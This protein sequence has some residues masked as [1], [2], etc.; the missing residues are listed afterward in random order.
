MNSS[1]SSSDPGSRWRRF[2]ATLL[3]VAVVVLGSIIAA[4]YMA[5]PYDTGRSTLMDKPGVRPQGPRT[6]AASRGRDPAFNA[7]IVGNSHI[8]LL[9][10]ERLKAS[11]G[12]DFVQLSV[13]ASGPQ[14]HFT[15]IGWFLRNR[16]EPARAVVVSA[17][18]NWCTHDP[19]LP[20]EKPFPFWL[21]AP[22]A[23]GYVRGLLRYDILEELPRRFGYVL[24]PEAERARPDG[25][26]DYEPNYIGLGYDRDPVLRQRLLDTKP[27]A[28]AV[29][30]PRDQRAG[31]RRFPAAN[32]L[33]DL[34][35]SLPPETALV[36][37]FPATFIN[38]LPLAGTKAASLDGACKAAIR[39]AV[40]AHGK[41]AILDWRLDRPENRNASL[42]FDATHYRH[43]IARGIERDIAQALKSLD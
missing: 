7:A 30:H 18:T 20:N 31:E 12:L 19:A 39:E 10:P 43:P 13:P 4:A 36:V 1:I 42:Y 40:A 32:R 9:S 8:Q 23:L 15:L 6:A 27:P 24:D 3:V 22:D 29:T 25:Y 21:F 34:A 37:V 41:S 35:A 26:W 11:T 28:E 14:E 2:T 38:Q 16:K 17:D 33:R 5:D